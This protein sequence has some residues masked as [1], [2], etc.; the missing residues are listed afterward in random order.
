MTMRCAAAVLTAM[1]ACGCANEPSQQ[2]AAASFATDLFL[3]A[4]AAF[5]F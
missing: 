2:N 1:V 3:Q 5:L 4:L